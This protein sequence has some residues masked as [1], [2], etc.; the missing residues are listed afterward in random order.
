MFDLINSIVGI[1]LLIC[2]F[3]ACSN[4]SKIKFYLQRLYRMEKL[5]MVEDGYIDPK[6]NQF[7]KWD[8]GDDELIK[9]KG[10]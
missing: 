1:V 9:P 8:F 2:F 4:L 5:R 7:K 10:E 6:D 3:I